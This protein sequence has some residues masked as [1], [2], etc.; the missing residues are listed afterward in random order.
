MGGW[1][2]D[3]RVEVGGTDLVVELPE[4]HLQVVDPLTQAVSLEHLERADLTSRVLDV[5]AGALIEAEG[6]GPGGPSGELDPEELQAFADLQWIEV[7]RSVEAHQAY[8]RK[9]HSAVGGREVLAFLLQDRLLPRSVL[10][11]MEQV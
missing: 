2:D 4:Q 11:C 8:R 9:V 6:A 5:R 7:L 3:R 1:G 10:H